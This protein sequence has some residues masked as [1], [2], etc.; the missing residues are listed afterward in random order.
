MNCYQH[1]DH[2]AVALCRVCYRGMCN[3]CVP[4][5]AVDITCSSICA[6]LV[7]RQYAQAL[8]WI[9]I[10]LGMVFLGFGV[11]EYIFYS[12]YWSYF[13]ILFGL[14]LIAGEMIHKAKI[15]RARKSLRYPDG[16]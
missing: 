5:H 14:I 13:L 6:Q 8:N 12:D 10:S 11:W 4:A 9:N 7:E 16:S 1:Q 3:T 2:A 15:N